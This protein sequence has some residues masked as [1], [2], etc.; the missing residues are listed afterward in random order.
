MCARACACVRACVSVCARARA[1]VRAF[2]CARFLR[3][4]L[5]LTRSYNKKIKKSGPIDF[6]V[7]FLS[8]SASEEEEDES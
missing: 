8:T 7:P 1:Y 3:G 2:V 5:R 4:I 6:Y